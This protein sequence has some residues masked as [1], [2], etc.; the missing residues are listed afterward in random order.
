MIDRRTFLGIA[1]GAGA[2]L[3]IPPHLLSGA[4]GSLI[5]Q[6]RLIQRAIPSSGEMLPVVGLGFAD[7]AGCADPAAL[8]DVLRTFYDNGGK[9]FDT[10]QT[11]G[12]ETE[13]FHATVASELGIQ[14]KLFLGLKG[15]PGRGGPLTDPAMAKAHVES[16]LARFKVSRLDL[17]Q[18]PPMADPQYWAAMIEAKKEGRIRYL[19]AAITSFG[20]IPLFESVMRNQPI[21]F[22]SVDYRIDSRDA[23]DKILPLAQERKIAVL[24]IFPFGGANGQSCVSGKGLFARVANTPLP[25]WAAEFDAKTWAQFFLKYVISH[26]A[27][28]TVRTGTTKP[29]HMLDN[30]GGG[31]GRL[32]DEAMR[33]RMV[34]F[35][36][37]TPL[38]VPVVSLDRYAG[39]YHSASGS[40]VIFRRDGETLFVKSGS[41]AEVPLAA[42][43]MRRFADAEG[44]VYEF[45]LTGVGPATRSSGV[46]VEQGGQ[47]IML[48]KK[49]ANDRQVAALFTHGSHRRQ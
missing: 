48:E 25:A 11:S 31:I 3:A 27:I 5:H 8:K 24:A 33:K 13:Q 2:S 17:V 10:L 12:A 23:E 19:G 9:V 20:S 46:V 41:R 6:Q 15:Y 22:I 30:I 42:R 35:V 21:D 34:E 14:D 18:V 16:L 7:H 29:H 26:P 37:R 45:Q 1:A 39:E 28:T 49:Q 40:V 43:T 4:G 44:T 38:V 32:P 36:E 47:R